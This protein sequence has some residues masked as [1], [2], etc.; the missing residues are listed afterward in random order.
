M[1]ATTQFES[2]DARRAF[3]CLDEPDMK[4]TF[5]VGLGR[6]KNMK[7]LS[8]ME[9]DGDAVEIDAT[10]EMDMYKTSV[11]MSTYLLAFIVC[12]FDSF[13]VPGLSYKK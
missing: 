5:T 6:K 7:T 2:T 4:A 11:K 1:I 12:E 3:P 8:N 13:H 10:Y 9:K